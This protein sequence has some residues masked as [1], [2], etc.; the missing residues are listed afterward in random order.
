LAIR[1]CGRYR[2]TEP[3]GSE[4]AAGTGQV[5]RPAYANRELAG[6]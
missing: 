1:A 3:S 4:Y 5:G 6:T 2:R